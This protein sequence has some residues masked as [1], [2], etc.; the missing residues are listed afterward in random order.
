M[1]LS[2]K[3]INFTQGVCV[4]VCLL[5]VCIYV[6]LFIYSFRSERK[7]HEEEYKFGTLGRQINHSPTPNLKAM[8]AIVKGCLRVGFLA[9]VDIQPNTE[10]TFHYGSQ[11]KPPD[12]IARTRDDAAINKCLDT[13]EQS[14]HRHSILEAPQISHHHEWE[15]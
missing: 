7:E 10:L 5:Y 13:Q 9:L 2:M 11:P 4:Q 1:C 15:V 14:G 12:F 3:W 8:Q 6:L